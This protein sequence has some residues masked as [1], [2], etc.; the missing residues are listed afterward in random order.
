MAPVGESASAC[1][2]SLTVTCVLNHAA[3]TRMECR[4]HSGPM[5]TDPLQQQH[6]SPRRVL[7]CSRP[8]PGG[9]CT[10]RRSPIPPSP[11]GTATRRTSSSLTPQQQQQ[12]ELLVSMGQ[13]D[14]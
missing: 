6:L 12:T 13:A 5:P 10:T 8:N 7:P 11:S 9:S 1:G 3:A 4:R 2:A 14:G